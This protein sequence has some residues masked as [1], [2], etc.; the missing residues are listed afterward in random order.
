[1]NPNYKNGGSSEAKS[2]KKSKPVSLL[3][4][5]SNLSINEETKK[6]RVIGG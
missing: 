2:M 4:V 5:F 3:R 1:M 6:G